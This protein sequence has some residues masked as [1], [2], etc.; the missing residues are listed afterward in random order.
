MN[1]FPLHHHLAMDAL[2]A[3]SCANGY[4]YRSP[5]IRLYAQS[6][7]V[8]R[9]GS[10]N[11]IYLEAVERVPGGVVFHNARLHVGLA[12]LR[13]FFTDLTLEALTTVAD[14]PYQLGQSYDGAMSA[15]V[16][17]AFKAACDALGFDADA[18]YR[19]AY[20][21]PEE[22]PPNWDDCREEADWQGG[23]AL[24]SQW[25]AAAIGGLQES[26]TEMNYHSLVSVLA[27]QCA[28]LFERS[29]SRQ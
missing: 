16:F 20:P 5:S 17:T 22:A 1:M 8:C 14:R 19:Q 13:E 24:P 9:V 18:L 7:D 6:C 29:P 25:D 27:K 12:D 21:R 23:V 28:H 3:A 2:R 15:P 11:Q 4:E 10:E 26:L